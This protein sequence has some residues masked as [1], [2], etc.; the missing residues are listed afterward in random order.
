MTPEEEKLFELMRSAY[1]YRNLQRE[2]FDQVLRMLSE[3]FSTKRGRRG[4]LI[5]HDAINHRV[6]GRR[7]GG[8]DYCV[9]FPQPEYFG[10]VAGP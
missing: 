2:E 9:G 7:K 4:A 5:H 6:R 8:H 1:P 10:D 3:G